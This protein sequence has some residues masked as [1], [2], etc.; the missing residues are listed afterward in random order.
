MRA[1]LTID[2]YGPWDYAMGHLPAILREVA[3][4]LDADDDNEHGAGF[5][6]DAT[7]DGVCVGELRIDEPL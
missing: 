4:R 5:R 6:M 2:L 7:Y 1:T 3:A